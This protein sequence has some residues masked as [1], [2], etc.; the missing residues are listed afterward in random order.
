[1][2]NIVR[3]DLFVPFLGLNDYRPERLMTI[4]HLNLERQDASLAVGC[5]NTK[6][7]NE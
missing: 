5:D 6:P 7:V 1:L 4:L 3:N 2:V